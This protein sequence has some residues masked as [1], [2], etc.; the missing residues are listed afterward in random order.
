[1]VFASDSL[2]SLN[3]YGY[4]PYPLSQYIDWV[5]T[6]L[7]NRPDS[8]KPIIISITSPLP[9]DGETIPTHS[10]DVTSREEEIIEPSELDGGSSHNEL[11]EMLA[12]IQALRAEFDD[13]ISASPR[14]AVEI[15]TSCPNI[16]GHPPPSYDIS[17]LRPLIQ[18]VTEVF[19]ADPSLAVG[20][21]L[22]PYV[23]ARQFVEVIDFIAS[24]T[25]DVGGKKRNPIAFLTCTNTLG[26]SLMFSDQ[27]VT[28]DQTATTETGGFAL[29]AVWGGLAGESLH[30]L[31]LG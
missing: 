22:P 28:N 7:Q 16:E 19:K 3:C 17:S 2:S 25:Q 10:L 15:N 20:I 13:P 24:F 9:H 11:P 12:T 29:P 23:Y 18:S 21:K 31:S 14:I 30:P 26:S 1:M 8:N 4:S 5:R 27:V 6:I